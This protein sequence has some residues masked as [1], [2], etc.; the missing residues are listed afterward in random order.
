MFCVDVQHIKY[1]YIPKSICIYILK[2]VI[3]FEFFTSISKCKACT[4]NYALY[5]W[6][7]VHN[8]SLIICII[9]VGI[10]NIVYIN[11]VR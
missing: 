11:N 4:G 6:H 1:G 10:R 7:I 2:L 3:K 8:M 5:V 9:H